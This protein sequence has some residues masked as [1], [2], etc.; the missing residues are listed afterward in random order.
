TSGFYPMMNELIIRG[1][2]ERI[3]LEDH[4]EIVVRPQF[5]KVITAQ[6]MTSAKV[7]SRIDR[8]CVGSTCGFV[9]EVIVPIVVEGVVLRIAFGFTLRFDGLF[10]IVGHDLKVDKPF[11]HAHM[12]ALHTQ[13]LT[14]VETPSGA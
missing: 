11:I 10:K 1:I 9:E 6:I 2:V 14:E 12:H 3:I 5:W 4:V 8:G 13:R 7:S